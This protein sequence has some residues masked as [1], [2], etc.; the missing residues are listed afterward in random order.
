VLYCVLVAAL[1]TAGCSNEEVFRADDNRPAA[2][3]PPQLLET[4]PEDV[5]PELVVGETVRFSV[6]AIDPNG[7]DL[8]CEFS[9]DDEIVATDMHFDF[10]A[11]EK[12]TKRVRAAVSDG[13]FTVDHEWLPSVLEVG[14]NRPPKLLGVVPADATPET[15]IGETIRF[16]V[17]ASDP[18]GNELT[19]EF[20][21]NDSAVTNET[22]FDY[23][24]EEKGTVHVRVTV[25]DGELEVGHD[26]VLEVFDPA[27]NRPPEIRVVFPED[28]TPETS[29]GETIRFSVQATDPEGGELSFRFFL[30]DVLVS[31]NPYYEF[32]GNRTGTWRV[33][34]VVSDGRDEV[35][36]EWLLEV[37]DTIPPADVQIV[38]VESGPLPR[39]IEVRWLAVGDDGLEGWA[40]RYVVG[41][42]DSPIESQGDWVRAVKYNVERGAVDPGT[43][44]QLVVTRSRIGQW[45]AV[46]VRA[47][48][49]EDNISAMVPYVAGYTCGFSCSGEVVSVTGEPIA[50]AFVY[51]GDEVV[52]TDAEGMWSVKDLPYLSDGFTV[53]DDGVP[54]SMGEFYD[55]RYDAPLNN[56]EHVVVRMFPY[57]QMESTRHTVF[58]TFFD[59]LTEKYFFGWESY[60]RHLQVPI[61]IYAHPFEKNGLDY[62]ATIERVAADLAS[63]IGFDA[64]HVVDAPPAVGVECFYIHDS[65]ED[66]RDHFTPTEWTEDFHLV[67]GRIE[68]RTSY[69]PKDITV[70]ERVIRHELGHALGLGHV[71]DPIYL[72]VGGLLAP[73]VDMFK[74]TEIRVLEII[75]NFVGDAKA[76][77]LHYSSYVDD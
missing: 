59:G 37:R 26:W 2:N 17:S 63:D 6:N 25:S 70:F 7:D 54:G 4:L 19:Y 69:E 33:R 8:N 11:A 64:F 58:L 21:L 73:Q 30:D 51:A 60:L 77:T 71:Q 40:S 13:R 38:S 68:F 1:A 16:S 53:S 35:D 66:D 65:E 10:T 46:V 45:T 28:A 43:E 5:T 27:E 75:H 56:G 42:S 18:D 55:Y 9:V 57:Y 76:D 67:K 50:G 24:A 14:Q 34:I 48:D 31:T 20:T 52:V 29:I 72:M 39:Q 74:P 23:P 41:M 62:K 12:G 61:D 22:F 32:T 15:L 36:H 47:V 49:D 44:M 3:K